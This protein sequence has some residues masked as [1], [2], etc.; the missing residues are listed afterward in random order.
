MIEFVRYRST[1][2]FRNSL[3]AGAALLVIACGSGPG[4]GPSGPGGSLGG[5]PGGPELDDVPDKTA[6]DQAYF[7][8]VLG[9][10]RGPNEAAWGEKR[11]EVLRE[12]GRVGQEFLLVL[13]AIVEQRP[14]STQQQQ[15]R[16]HRE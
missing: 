16:A 12:R 6:E 13:L 11:E 15:N 3:L 4:P 14:E 1:F 2:V 9:V 8:E 10:Y 5:D 7:R